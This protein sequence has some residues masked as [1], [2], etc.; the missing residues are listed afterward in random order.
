MERLKGRE[1]EQ[2]LKKLV[3]VLREAKQC[4]NMQEE[5]PDR[6]RLENSHWKK[7]IELSQDHLLLLLLLL[8][9]MMMM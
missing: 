6:N 2:E 7:T 9:M 8:L 5:T 4:R 1:Q 3:E